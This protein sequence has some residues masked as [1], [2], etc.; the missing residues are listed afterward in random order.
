MSVTETSV[1]GSLPAVG[2]WTIDPSHSTVGFTIRHMMVSKVRGRFGAFEGTI[3][4][5]QDPL[6]SSVAATIDAASIDS[7]DAKRD[8]HLRSGDFLDT[9]RFPSLSF[10][11]HSVKEAADGGYVLA[12]DLTIRDV[13]RPVEL[14]LQPAGVA[15]DPW[16][17]TRAGFEA[18]TEISRKDYGLEW[19]LALETGGFVLGDKV[20]ID[21]DIE[22]VADK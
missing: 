10:V 7:R 4:I 21:L 2:T 6:A 18:S 12:G 13:T 8:E 1:Q 20:R 22:A 5:A 16:G 9:E 19:N 3:T 11:S 14:S 17:G 15:T